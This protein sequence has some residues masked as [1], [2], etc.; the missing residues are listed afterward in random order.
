M[1]EASYSMLTYV[2]FPETEGQQ[3]TAHQNKRFAWNIQ[4]IK[5]RQSLALKPYLLVA[6]WTRLLFAFS[7]SED[8][9]RLHL[10]QWEMADPV[11]SDLVYSR[12]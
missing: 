5:Y 6:P 7:T 12:Y 4:H 11:S 2:S 8:Q 1:D 3:L 9:H 10:G